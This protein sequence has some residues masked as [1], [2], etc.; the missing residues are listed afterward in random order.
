[1]IKPVVP[2]VDADLAASVAVSW[3]DTEVLFVLSADRS[4]SIGTLFLLDLNSGAVSDG[5]GV[6]GISPAAAKEVGGVQID[7]RHLLVQYSGRSD[8]LDRAGKLMRSWSA[9]ATLR[10]FN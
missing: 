5:A 3:C 7:R 4:M 2:Q 9:Y 8:L 10:Q 1:M 6:L